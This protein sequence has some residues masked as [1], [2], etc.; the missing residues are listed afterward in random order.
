MQPKRNLILA[1]LIMQILAFW[2]VWRWYFQ[3]I[4]DSPEELAGL[5]G[6]GTA[7]FLVWYQGRSAG[8]EKPQL[9]WPILLTIL[10]T[11]TYPFTPPLLRAM[12]AF[13]AIGTA[14]TGLLLQSGF[15]LGIWGLLL[16]GL[17][18]IPTLQFYLGFPF[19]WMAAFI[20]A[21]LLNLTGFAVSQSGTCLNWSGNLMM[22]D[23]PCSGIKMLWT[24]LYLTLTLLTF[25]NFKLLQSCLALFW[26][27]VTVFIGNVLRSVTL[28]YLEA[29]IVKAP[30]WAHEGVGLI[31]FTLVAILI[32]VSIGFMGRWK[33]P[34]AKFI[35]F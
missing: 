25:Y 16:L 19:R 35:S 34:C 13:G 9:F 28:F 1:I 3:R 6:I 20:A 31:S 27:V 29:G 2:P 11:L 23:A 32:F 7:L 5:L 24:G 14:I 8:P 30:P 10:Y 26:A 17:P 12:F 33:K 22:I 21:P 18:V 4:T 15:H